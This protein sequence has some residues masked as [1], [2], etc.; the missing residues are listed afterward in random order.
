MDATEPADGAARQQRAGHGRR[1]TF[2]VLATLAV[3][4]VGATPTAS[5]AALGSVADGWS[6][7]TVLR[8][9]DGWWATPIEATL[10]P[11][12][13]TV[14]FVGLARN[15]DPA[16]PATPTRRE[17]WTMP[18]QALGSTMPSS[19][20]VNEVTEPVQYPANIVNG[21][22]QSDDLVCSGLTLTADGKVLIAGGTRVSKNMTTGVM[23]IGGLPYEVSFDGTSMTRL[24]APMAALGPL[25]DAER[26]YPTLT[27]LANGNILVTSGYEQVSPTPVPSGTMEIYNP[28]TGAST[29]FAA[30]APPQIVNRDFTHVFLLPSATAPDDLLLIGESGVPV[31]ASST[32]PGAFTV[33]ASGRPGWAGDG[34]NWGTSSTMLPLQTTNRAWGYDNGS[35][36]TVSGNMGSPFEHNAAVFDPV[37]GTYIDQYDV[38]VPRH[39]PDAVDL[40]DGRVLLVNGHDQGGDPRVQQAEYID[41]SQGFSV[42]LGSSSE[43]QVR[44]YHSIALLL[45][46]GRVL[47]G[48][49]RDQNTDTSLEKPSFQYYLPDYLSKTRLVITSAPT[50]LGYGSLFGTTSTGPV[51]TQAVL[52]ALGSDTHSFDEDQREI[53]LP[54]GQ[55]TTSG[56]TSTLIGGTP[57]N[58]HVA[59]PGY[60]MLFLLDAN[61]VPSVAKIVH[62]G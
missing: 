11:D 17:A 60:Y 7:S 9:P 41:P 1:R 12:G 28:T 34:T 30:N 56:G 18:L 29:V 6:A 47:V 44:G 25:A 50:T 58:S 46:D 57:A 13:N 15:A 39:H 54:V 10:M 49:G 35:V 2:V 48:G 51:P 37:T 14:L 42:A 27:R 52:I 53:Q 45:P 62:L 19:L 55:V 8:T 26:W 40:P 21:S 32:K 3:L 23:T 5:G 24:P 33:M 22:Y 43:G 36:L 38:V 20:T 61:R 16:T 31:E 4:F 59:P